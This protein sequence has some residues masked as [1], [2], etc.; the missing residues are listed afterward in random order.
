[1]DK[2]ILRKKM[3]KNLHSLSK[4]IS[5]A[6]RHTPWEYELELDE[7]G[8]VSI[9][10]L[11]RALKNENAKWQNLKIE[12]LVT[13][14]MLSDKKRHE[15]KDGKIRALYGHS[16]PSKLQKTQAIPPPI[17]YH[18]TSSQVLATIQKDGL[19]PMNRHYVHLSPSKEVAKQVGNRKSRTAVVLEINAKDAHVNGIKFYIGNEHVW[20]SDLIPSNFITKIS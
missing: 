20:L 9:L 17:L 6:L 8:W 10:D 12:D 18:G 19:K 1:M 7:E 5:C 15:I 3:N 16:T 11:L 4:T 2:N 13:M 14:I